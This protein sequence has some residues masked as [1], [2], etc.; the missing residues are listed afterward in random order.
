MYLY[1]HI[2]FKRLLFLHENPLEWIHDVI[3]VYIL[4]FLKGACLYLILQTYLPYFF[5]AATNEPTYVVS[6]ATEPPFR[7]QMTDNLRG[8]PRELPETPCLL[9]MPS[10]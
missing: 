2:F 7:Q 6:A 4:K 10:A 1:I 5:S 9:P 8:R 3:I